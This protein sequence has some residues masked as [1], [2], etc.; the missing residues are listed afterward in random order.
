MQIPFGEVRD[1]AHSVLC[2]LAH[3]RKEIV[4]WVL[5]Q[6]GHGARWPQPG[7]NS[8]DTWCTQGDVLWLYDVSGKCWHLLQ[9]LVL[10]QVGWCHWL[11]LL[12]FFG[13]LLLLLP[14]LLLLL[15]PTLRRMWCKLLLQKVVQCRQL[16]A[17]AILQVCSTL[18]NRHRS[19][20]CHLVEVLFIGV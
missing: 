3:L 20:P 18:F 12:L 13:L 15:S 6:W 8:A 14:L 2:I 10:R 17:P 11:L 19:A 16:R 4:L 9:Q 1:G 7:V 5:V